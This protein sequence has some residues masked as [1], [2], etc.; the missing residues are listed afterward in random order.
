MI[1]VKFYTTNS[2]KY[3]YCFNCVLENAH[4]D[5]KD[6]MN[7]STSN[8]LMMRLT[9]NNNLEPTNTLLSAIDLYVNVHQM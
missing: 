9:S 5:S 4:S 2:S 6:Y 1:Y 7:D 8:M 3:H